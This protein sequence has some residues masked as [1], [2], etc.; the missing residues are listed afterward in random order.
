M[1]ITSQI[2][3]SSNGSTAITYSIKKDISIMFSWSK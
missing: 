3:N 2:F 1:G